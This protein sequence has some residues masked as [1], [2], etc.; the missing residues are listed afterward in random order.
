M[1]F[2]L[3]YKREG[4][5]SFGVGTNYGW[6]QLWDEGTP[7]KQ[8]AWNNILAVFN[9]NDGFISLYLN[10]RIVNRMRY[11]CWNIY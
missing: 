1:G 2:T 9:G 8:Y 6:Y 10:G 11:P 7:L 5:Y 4:K 3:G